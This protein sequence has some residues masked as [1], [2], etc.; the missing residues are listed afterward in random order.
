MSTSIVFAMALA[1]LLGVALGLLG[2]GG[3]ILTVPI[4]TLVLGTGTREAIISSLFVVAITSAVSAAFRVGRSEVR[5]MKQAGF[6][7]LRNLGSLV[8]LE[9]GRVIAG[10]GRPRL[11]LQGRRASDELEEVAFGIGDERDG[12]ARHRGSPGR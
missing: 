6:S 4:F 9:H 1:V 12:Q 5:W 3:S 7:D 11:A 2:G 8:Q 10:A